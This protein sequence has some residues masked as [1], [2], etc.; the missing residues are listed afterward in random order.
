MYAKIEVPSYL[1]ELA[2]P[3]TEESCTVGDVYAPISHRFWTR[4]RRLADAS[5]P[6]PSNVDTVRT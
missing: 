6:V 3:V 1:P 4:A 2:K 5:V